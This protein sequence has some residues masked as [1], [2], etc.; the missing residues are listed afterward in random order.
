MPRNG[1]TPSERACP[2]RGVATLQNGL[3][4][5]VAWLTLAGPGLAQSGPEVRPANPSL[6]GPDYV[7]TPGLRLGRTGLT[8]GAFASVELDGEH[9]RPAVVALDSVNPLVLWEPLGLARA[10]AELEIGGLVSWEPG[11]GSV[12]SS[13][14]VRFERLYAEVSAGDVLSARLGKFQTPVGLWNLVPAEPF[15]WTATNPVL[16][17][18]AFDEHQTGA[19][20]FGSLY[21]GATTVEYWA[22]GQ[23][24]DPLHPDEGAMDRGAGGRLRVGG[25]R[26]DW[27]VGASFLASRRAGEWNRLAGLDA[28]WGRGSLELQTEVA[29][30]QGEIP[31]RDFSGGYLQAAYHLGAHS[32]PLRGLHLVAR[33]ERFVASSAGPARD[34][35]NVGLAWIPKPFLNVKATYQLVD[36]P[37]PMAGLGAFGSVS[38]IF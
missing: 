16:V 37:S 2:A 38:F 17:D 32:A 12:E 14:D 27:A 9:G 8:I 5:L 13:P 31:G 4:A 23:F 26:G 18:A 10:F 19:A 28:F 3:L 24:L 29:V 6:V 11:T 21:P 15:T 35:G 34:V 25:A 20:L 7:A 30:V 1:R 36:E 33:Y 22:Y